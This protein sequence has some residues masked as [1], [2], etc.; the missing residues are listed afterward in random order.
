MHTS[1]HLVMELELFCTLARRKAPESPSLD[2]FLRE[3]STVV[4]SLLTDRPLWEARERLRSVSR[5]QPRSWVTRGGR[6]IH[7]YR[8]EDVYLE[9]DGYAE[10][11]STT[12]DLPHA[13]TRI[14]PQALA[15][16]Y[17]GAAGEA[18]RPRVIV[19]HPELDAELLRIA[20]HPV[21]DPPTRTP[22]AMVGAGLF[23]TLRALL[24]QGSLRQGAASPVP[25]RSPAPS[26]WGTALRGLSPDRT[27]EGRQP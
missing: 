27:F 17:L 11:I 8:G 2:A 25:S 5:V 6:E 23:P 21:F 9:D 15:V 12:S 13:P 10:A 24:A 19:G 18:P 1:L 14:D 20:D 3:H 22:K 16:A 4:L 26:R 7:L